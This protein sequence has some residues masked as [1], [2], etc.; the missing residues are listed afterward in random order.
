M[1]QRCMLRA[2]SGAILLCSVLLT[3]TAKAQ[4]I[5]SANF[6][7]PGCR[8]ILSYG[9]GRR[10]SLDDDMVNATEC[11]AVVRS[12]R[13]T[14]HYLPLRIASCPPT[15]VT[16]GQMIRVVIAYIDARPRRMHEDFRDLVLEALHQ[17]WPC[18]PPGG[19]GR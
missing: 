16:N 1:S 10:P 15:Q 13:F 7:L 8:L 4:D 12:L 17:A 2:K 5:N 3:L 11:S 9:D 18:P 6:L 14:S 19:T